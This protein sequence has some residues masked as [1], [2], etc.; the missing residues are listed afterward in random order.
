MDCLNWPAGMRRALLRVRLFVL[1]VVAGAALACGE[2]GGTVDDTTAGAAAKA[3][4][5]SGSESCRPCHERFYRLWAPSHHGLAMQPFSPEL[6]RE[7]LMPQAGPLALD[8]ATYQAVLDDSG[9]RVVERA[10]AR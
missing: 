4:P 10:G 6:A 3:G 7:R 9:G 1:V 2:R 8:G 5:F